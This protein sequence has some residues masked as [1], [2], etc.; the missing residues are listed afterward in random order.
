MLLACGV[1][2]STIVL[3]PGMQST[4]PL[5]ACSA[6]A[7]VI[8]ALLVLRPQIAP[9]WS[10]QA[11][12]ALVTVLISL[13][14]ATTDPNASG[15]AASVEVFYVLVA[16]YAFYFF[17]ARA[18]LAQVVFAGASY[19]AVLWHETSASTGLARWG[20]TVAGMVVAGMMVRAMNGEVDRLVGELDATAAR[21]PLTGALNRRGLQ[22]R[23]GIELTRARRAREP[24]SLVAADLDGLKQL[25]D[26]HGHA[27]GDEAL[28]LVADVVA[29]ELR[30]VDVLARIG[31][32]EFV[33]V[34]PNCDLDSGVV[35]AEDLRARVGEAARLESWPV[36]LSLGV[37]SAP[38]LPL[39]PEALLGAADAALYRAKS[40]GRNRVS[41]AG[42]AELR[43]ALAAG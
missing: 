34:L 26:G 30:D 1:L 21:D 19:A 42:R 10:S 29:G 28:R 37:A 24:V 14:A 39:D 4:A 7:F 6:V 31:G 16:I 43:G 22:E 23:L 35:I 17:S 3:L 27:A 25:N 9:R 33:I 11:M 15:R 38:P 40:L 12:I 32:D 13:A 41:R 18:G 36:T 8:G 20:T 5:L 2:G